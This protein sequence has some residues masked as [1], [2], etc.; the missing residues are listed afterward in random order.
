MRKRSQDGE[1]ERES[2]HLLAARSGG[3]GPAETNRSLTLESTSSAQ[4]QRAPRVGLQVGLQRTYARRLGERAKAGVGCVRNV[5][6][7]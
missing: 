1:R 7:G 3:P 6:L 2:I 4:Q 5:G